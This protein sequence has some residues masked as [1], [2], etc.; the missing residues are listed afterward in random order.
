MRRENIDQIVEVGGIDEETV[1]KKPM[2][3][4]NRDSGWESRSAVPI[5]AMVVV[6]VILAG[7]QILTKL[8]IN[9]GKQVFAILT[10]RHMAATLC[11]APLAFLFDRMETLKLDSRWGRFK[12]V[13]G[14]LCVGEALVISQTERLFSGRRE[15]K[16][17][18]LPF[19]HLNSQHW[20]VS[21]FYWFQVVSV[22]TY[23]LL[24]RISK[25]F[26]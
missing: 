12:I 26:F 15:Y 4:A 14:F 3:A 1:K 22:M 13:G 19:F 24:H 20:S 10:Y 5:V 6:Q 25:G 9:K 18:S 2:T 8:A 11:I 17:I 16:G 7:S 21:P 23:G